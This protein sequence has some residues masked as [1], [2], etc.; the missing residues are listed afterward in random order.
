LS[1][2]PPP[3]Y[4]LCPRCKQIYRATSNFCVR[5]RTQLLSD[6]RIIV[7]KYILLSQI[8]TGRMSDVFLAEQPHLGRRVVIKLL[9]HDPEVM[10]RFDSEVLAVGRIR[11]DH[12][13]TIH[14]SGWTDEG[15]PYLAME[16]LEGQDLAAAL[17]QHGPIPSERALVL[18][19][20]AVQALAAAHRSQVIH[21][22]VKPANLLLTTR[23]GDDGPEEIVKVIDF[24]IAKVSDARDEQRPTSPG[25]LLGTM[26]YMAPEQLTRGEAL[27]ASDVYSLGVVLVEMMTGTVPP[28]KPADR[29]QVSVALL[30]MVNQST[31]S[32]ELSPQRPLSGQL[33][34]LVDDM[35]SP[36]PEARPEDA[37][38]LLRRVKELPEVKAWVRSPGLPQALS[39]R[40]ATPTP[41][42]TLA[43]LGA[44][45]LPAPPR[46]GEAAADSSQ[47][48]LTEQVVRDGGLDLSAAASL[49]AVSPGQ[50][51]QPEADGWF[52][53]GDFGTE[54]PTLPTTG[55]TTAERDVRALVQI[56]SQP[57]A[58]AE[59]LPQ[60]SETPRLSPEPSLPSSPALS[61]GNPAAEFE[62]VRPAAPPP[63]DVPAGAAPEVAAPSSPPPPAL[64][65]EQ[66]PTLALR[67]RGRGRRGVL[68]AGLLGA[69]VLFL[70]LLVLLRSG[71]RPRPQ[72]VSDLGAASVAVA[73]AAA[74]DAAAAAGDAGEPEPVP[75]LLQ[76]VPADLRPAAPAPVDL[77]AP[78][79]GA[80]EPAR[81]AADTEPGCP[82]L[83]LRFV[84]RAEDGVAEVRCRGQRVLPRSTVEIGP[85]D[86]CELVGTDGSR[87]ALSY[88]ALARVPR[89][90]GGIRR[91]HPSLGRSATPTAPATV[92]ATA[93]VE[94][95]PPPP[96]DPEPARR[97][98][99][100]G[101]Q[102]GS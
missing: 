3:A 83:R 31:A 4:K 96:A 52:P 22:D 33:L 88:A 32:L 47:P 63:A 49:P 79:P 51:G 14:D 77:G 71:R 29:G 55:H 89:S 42:P 61:T 98:E 26:P 76:P 45:P 66:L 91:Y 87:R 41:T 7:G 60:P 16:Y 64:Q 94:P 1:P 78:D 69:A 12:V 30:R 58:S 27:P 73:D 80:E 101:A 93:P 84:V 39:L 37:G 62:A 17:R 28:A 65:E 102:D 24:S 75:A 38:A 57:A 10:R 86:A 72:A 25:A 23:D 11:H 85:E 53:G 35:L 81:A 99:P 50:P 36:F 18:W 74:V 44:R 90:R 21:R 70:G 100:T 68:A 8:G 20:Q 40:R 59:S 15:R 13:V 48:S 43:T 97:P 6:G 19:L 95:G 54:E 2:T 46:P 5:D 82:V 34:E 92:P 67:R 56:L 9:H